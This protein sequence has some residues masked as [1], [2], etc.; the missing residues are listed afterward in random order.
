MTIP[1]RVKA[2]CTRRGFLAFGWFGVLA[3]ALGGRPP[4]G[5]KPKPTPKPT[6]TPVAVKTVAFSPSGTAAQLLALLAD[7][8]VDVIELNG[9]YRLPQLVI[10]TNRT[11]RVTVRPATGASA[12]FTATNCPSGNQFALGAGGVAGL[13]RFADIVLDGYRVNDTGLFGIGNAHDITLSR[14]TVRNCTAGLSS[15]SSWALYVTS[16]GGTGPV[17]LV[18]DDWTVDGNGRA[19]SAM[20]SYHDPNGRGVTARRWNVSHVGYALYM[21]SDISGVVLDGWTVND[22]GVAGYNGVESI[23]AVGPGNA[24]TIANFHVTNGG[25]VRIPSLT[26]AGGNTWSYG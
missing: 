12:V 17:N 20:Q 13:I 23:I 16:D 18:A 14:I 26:D 9:T 8:T 22:A 7:N 21:N 5:R 24:G 2:E 25:G 4:L 3:L 15:S 10:N 1:T 19:I 11:R 6:P